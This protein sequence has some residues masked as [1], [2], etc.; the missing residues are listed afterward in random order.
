MHD[1]MGP[2]PPAMRP[3]I[4]RVP[5]IAPSLPQLLRYV[6]SAGLRVLI[7]RDTTVHVLEF[8]NQMKTAMS[9]APPQAGSDGEAS[10]WNAAVDGYVETLA[11]LGGADRHTYRAAC[12]QLRSSTNRGWK[13]NSKPDTRSR[14]AVNT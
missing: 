7:W 9:K 2:L 5:C 12:R 1:Q 6:D 3:M 10:W 14:T 4:R 8:F 13:L 11:N